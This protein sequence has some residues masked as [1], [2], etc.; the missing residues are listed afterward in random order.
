MVVTEHRQANGTTSSQARF[1]LF[2]A[3]AYPVESKS[4]CGP[5]CSR[6]RRG[7]DLKPRNMMQAILLVVTFAP[8][9]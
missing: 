5:S 2:S 1:C 8:P 4:S 9:F 7:P 3:S 6:R